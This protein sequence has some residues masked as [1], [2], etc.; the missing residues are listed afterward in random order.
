MPQELLVQRS[1]RH[2]GFR[3]AESYRPPAPGRDARL[4]RLLLEFPIQSQTRFG[5]YRIADSSRYS[6]IARSVE[7]SVFEEF[8]G[9]VPAVMTEAYGGYE[10]HS[11]FL[12]VVDRELQQPAG[13]LRVI[14][15]SPSGLKTLNDIQG[16]PLRL[17]TA[18]VMNYHHIS[19]LSRCWDVGTLAVLKP[20]R[21]QATDHLVSTMLYGL[22]YRELCRA[23]IEHLITVLDKHAYRQ[24]T[25]MLG[26]PFVPIA[27]S[28]PFDYL[29]SAS[30]RA[31]YV[32]V[33]DVKSAVDQFMASLPANVR[34]LLQP[35]TSRL[36]DGEGLPD[37]VPVR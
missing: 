13:A 22:L 26:V 35:Y 33:P 2:S 6:D 16:A 23:G 1:E 8:F 15:H 36:I 27:G 7:C 12:L 3:P 28:E 19:D 25:E 9:N 20:Y 5:C 34:C 14:E 37:V 29:G 11:M 10:A 17:P 18:K 30:S 21:G 32:H 4:L 31:S 24:L